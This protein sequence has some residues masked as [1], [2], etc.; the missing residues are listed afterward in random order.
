MQ[1][2]LY[3]LNKKD[4]ITD[5]NNQNQQDLLDENSTLNDWLSFLDRQSSFVNTNYSCH[6]PNQDFE[7]LEWHIKEFDNQEIKFEGNKYASFLKHYALLVF[8]GLIQFRNYQ[9][10]NFNILFLTFS[11]NIL[12]KHYTFLGSKHIN[13]I[14]DL[15]YRNYDQKEKSDEYEMFLGKSGKNKLE[16]KEDFI[17][18]YRLCINHSKCQIK[19]QNLL[20]QENT[21][22]FMATSLEVLNENYSKVLS[23]LSYLEWNGELSRWIWLLNQNKV[24]ESFIVLCNLIEKSKIVASEVNQYDFFIAWC[25]NYIGEALWRSKWNL[26][27]SGIKTIAFTDTLNVYFSAIRSS[28]TQNFYIFKDVPF[29]EI[30]DK[31]SGS[32][33][34]ITGKIQ[35][36]NYAISKYLRKH[37]RE[38]TLILLMYVDN[39]SSTKKLIFQGPLIS[40]INQTLFDLL[41]VS[42]ISRLTYKQLMLKSIIEKDTNSEFSKSEHLKNRLSEYFNTIKQ[43]IYKI[44]DENLKKMFLQI[45]NKTISQT[46][47]ENLIIKLLI[48]V[49]KD[50]RIYIREGV[51]FNNMKTVKSLFRKAWKEPTNYSNF[52]VNSKQSR[53]NEFSQLYTHLPL[54]IKVIQKSAEYQNVEMNWD[55]IFSCFEKLLGKNQNIIMFGCIET[56]MQCIIDEGMYNFKI[57]L[58]DV[59]KTTPL[60]QIIMLS[61]DVISEEHDI[62]ELISSN[63]ETNE[64]ERI[65]DLYIR[66]I[67]R[68]LR[69]MYFMNLKCQ[70]SMLYNNLND[71]KAN[72]EDQIGIYIK[73]FCVTVRLSWFDDID[74]YNNTIK[75]A[76]N[77]LSKLINVDLVSKGKLSLITNF[78]C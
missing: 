52:H 6:K 8:Y 45:V 48:I 44:V 2:I 54:I 77:I 23:N 74:N 34:V 42:W 7:E 47:F 18:N 71:T 10:N 20:S 55:Q 35:E 70:E 41:I 38:W 27:L 66:Q 56:I 75:N 69:I 12:K 15:V 22:N 61:K 40:N 31:E 58:K 24:N 53:L 13:K 46:D 19:F 1:K 32:F 64:H 60:D 49:P 26:D 3:K 30:T 78:R 37:I 43:N 72:P 33:S 73:L 67:L 25:I 65:N 21:E 51:I 62:N 14:V 50:L 5:W 11:W 16:G 9:A 57:A 17:E 59:S 63:D 39:W 76:L 4:T 28:V 29:E 36:T 68:V